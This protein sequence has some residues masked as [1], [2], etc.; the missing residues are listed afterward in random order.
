MNKQSRWLIA[1]AERWKA[2]GLVSPVQ[3]ER[4]RERYT[5]SAAAMPWG[6]VIFASAGAV[7]IG[8]GVILLFAYNWNDIPKFGKLGLVF[9][10]V[11]AAHA[12]GLHLRRLADWR[13]QIGAALNLLGTMFYGAG[14]WLVAQVYHIDEHYPN[15]FLFWALGAL[16]LAWVLDSVL[17][18]LLAT[19]LLAIWGGC[20]VLDFHDPNLWALAVV[21]FGIGPLAWRRKS[22]VLLS[23]VLVAV[24][25][26]LISNLSW[27][28]TSAHVFTTSFA[29]G[30]LL[31]AAAR[32]TPA[33]DT[34][35]PGAAKVMS[36]FGFA[37]FIVCS[38]LLSFAWASRYVVN[39]ERVPASQQGIAMAHSWTFFALAVAGWA[40]VA[41]RSFRNRNLRSV[42]EEW[43][44]P[45]ALI[46]CY[47]LVWG[48]YAIVTQFGTRLFNVILLG[49][50]GAWI[51][52]GSREG[53]LRETVLGVLL[54]GVVVLARYFDLF[55]SL[56][57]RGLAFVVFGGVLL[58]VVFFFRKARK[59][60]AV[61]GG[62]A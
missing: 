35:F 56:A 32:L 4:I 22:A 52:R 54:L 25:F 8:L 6:L 55:Q 61:E 20:E 42:A 3:F 41:V 62:Q 14:I 57:A 43:L 47:A 29:F 33:D 24:Q 45:V 18:A 19:V 59:Q 5:D 10:A 38:Y 51:W 34:A 31:I 58:S 48:R 60:D 7:V 30:A 12:G 15:G 36:F 21:V 53:Q 26:L 28:G 40:L 1:E 46:Y 11:I 17:Q 27:F 13:P 44:V 37:G 50:A 23:V 39:W 9:G 49:L 2:E 16:V